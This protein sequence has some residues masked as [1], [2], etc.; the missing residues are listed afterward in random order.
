MKAPSTVRPHSSLPSQKR[1]MGA[2]RKVCCQLSPSAWRLAES[3]PCIHGSHTPRNSRGALMAMKSRLVGSFP[4]RPHCIVALHIP[5]GQRNSRNAGSVSG[6]CTEPA[7]KRYCNSVPPTTKVATTQSPC[8]FG[9]PLSIRRNSDHAPL[10]SSV[11]G[12]IACVCGGGGGPPPPNPNRGGGCCCCCCC[13]CC[14]GPTVM[15][16]RPRF[17]PGQGTETGEFDPALLSTMVPLMSSLI[18]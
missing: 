2:V 12:C 14:S 16:A 10:R 6:L 1:Q 15:A 11:E 8:R 3:P 17:V 7:R 4:Y 9:D 5:W 18:E 13:C